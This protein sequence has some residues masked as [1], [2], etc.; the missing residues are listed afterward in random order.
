MAEKLQKSIQVRDQNFHEYL[1]P[2]T[3]SSIYIQPSSGNE[4]IETINNYI[5][6]KKATGPNSIPA[7]I[8]QL[9]TPSIAE[10]LSDI[11]NISFSQGKYIDFLKISRIIAIYKEM[12]DNL[13]A[14][15]YRPISLLPN[16]NKIFEKIMHKRVYEFVEDK[17]ILYELQFGFRMFH[18]TQHALI[19]ITEDIRS[20]IDG[21][22]FALGVFID[23]QKA[24]DTVDHEILLLAT[25]IISTV[26]P[27]TQCCQ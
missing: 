13:M 27:R 18:S 3:E 5:I 15:N 12:G 10:P 21:N 6:N 23:L 17:N 24:F 11:I 20:A 14:K 22:M 25:I 16:I 19:D 7:F 2:E 26:N 9:I 8:L 4:V 1:P